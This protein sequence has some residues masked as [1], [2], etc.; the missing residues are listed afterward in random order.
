MQ[1]L[2]DRLYPVHQGQVLQG[3]YRGRK[4]RIYIPERRPGVVYQRKLVS[5][6]CWHRVVIIENGVEVYR[7][8][9]F[10]GKAGKAQ[11]IALLTPV[12]QTV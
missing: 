12:S 9:A 8:P 6:N 1:Y 4:K 7:S 11:A 2:D 3:K 10:R 5:N